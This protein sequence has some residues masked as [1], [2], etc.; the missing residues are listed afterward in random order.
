[1][2][3]RGIS[4]ALRAAGASLALR[5]HYR[6]FGVQLRKLRE[7]FG[8]GPRAG[9]SREAFFERA[10]AELEA[11]V[12]RA[13]ERQLDILVGAPGRPGRPRVHKDSEG[14]K[15]R[16]RPKDLSDEEA[17]K[18]VLEIDRLKIDYKVGR[19]S[20]SDRD[21]LLVLSQGDTLSDAA[22]I[23]LLFLRWHTA[24]FVERGLP[25]SEARRGART[26]LADSQLLIQSLRKKLS[27]LR[28]AHRVHGMTQESKRDFRRPERETS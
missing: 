22:A 3:N 24:G 27:G 13:R 17:E 15:L 7:K 19:L 9:E 2:S 16:G 4:W 26:K 18:W 28:R 5:R 21:D 12:R 1:V 25:E 6:L 23:K 14:R 20:A 10:T 8:G 11:I